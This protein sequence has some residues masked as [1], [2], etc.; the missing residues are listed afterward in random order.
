M[1]VGIAVPLLIQSSSATDVMV[2]GFQTACYL[3]IGAAI[4]SV[5][6]NLLASLTANRNGKRTALLNLT[7]NLLRAALMLTILTVFP[8]I[9]GWI[10]SLS[11]DSIG[12]QIAN[13]HTIFATVSVLTLL[14]FT[15][16]IVKFTEII[17]PKTPEES[18][19]V[20]ERKPWKTR[21]TMPGSA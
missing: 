6:P 7:F 14:P 11:P 16:W 17:L 18:R 4:G 1:L 13:A 19:V 12:R 20:E 8:R 5:T 21:W 2:I 3:C 15:G 9:F 10:E